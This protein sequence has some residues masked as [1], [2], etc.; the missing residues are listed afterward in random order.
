MFLQTDR[1]FEN[2]RFDLAANG[3]AVLLPFYRANK[4]L[5]RIITHER[6]LYDIGYFFEQGWITD[7]LFIEDWEA[8]HKALGLPVRYIGHQHADYPVDNEDGFAYIR[9]EWGNYG[10][11]TDSDGHGHVTYDPMGVGEVTTKGKPVS[12]RVFLW[13]D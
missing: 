1:A 13:T 12:T 9:H 6:I 3:C 7:D 11:F 8:I 4:H 2:T 5:G 10:H